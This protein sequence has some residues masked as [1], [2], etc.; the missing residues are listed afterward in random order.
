MKSIIPIFDNSYL[1]LPIILFEHHYY[2][3]FYLYKIFC[4]PGIFAVTLSL[5]NRPPHNS[6]LMTAEI[7]QNVY[8]DLLTIGAANMKFDQFTYL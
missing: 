8:Y 6:P 3:S 4:S 5:T 1:S 7:Y 2:F